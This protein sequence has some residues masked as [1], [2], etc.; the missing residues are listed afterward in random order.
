MTDLRSALLA[1]LDKRIEACR[2]VEVHSPGPWSVGMSPFYLYDANGKE[3]TEDQFI[4]GPTKRH[5]AAHDPTRML[6]LYEWL[7]IEVAKHHAVRSVLW[8]PPPGCWRCA[9]D[10]HGLL[11]ENDSCLFVAALAAAL[12]VRVAVKP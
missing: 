12:D 5:I 2:V 11:A 4:F 9:Q 1:E 7:R 3:V 8:N 6:A 10:Q